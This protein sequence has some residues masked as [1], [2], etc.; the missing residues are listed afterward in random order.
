[1]GAA[2]SVRAGA[3]ASSTLMGSPCACLRFASIFVSPLITLRLAVFAFF[4]S[5]VMRQWLILLRI[6]NEIPIDQ[7][8]GPRAA[9]TKGLPGAIPYQ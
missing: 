9:P 2:R 7:T 8:K 3:V 6:A 4:G 5:F 1:M